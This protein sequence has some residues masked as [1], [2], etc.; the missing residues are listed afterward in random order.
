MCVQHHVCTHIHVLTRQ[1][2]AAFAPSAR[3]AVTVPA[4]PFSLAQCNAERFRDQTSSRDHYPVKVHTLKRQCPAPSMPL[5]PADHHLVPIVHTEYHD[6]V[7]FLPRPRSLS[8]TPHTI[9]APTHASCPT[10]RSRA[11]ASLVASISSAA[12]A[13]CA[14]KH[15]RCRAVLPFCTCV[16]MQMRH[17]THACVG[18]CRRTSK[19]ERG[20][21]RG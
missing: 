20:I 14:L 9:H 17:S 16:Y 2:S 8:R 21:G 5:L 19:V 3:S 11:P 15:A 10:C 13:S 1:G 4:Q 7:P 6:Q 18:G 12:A